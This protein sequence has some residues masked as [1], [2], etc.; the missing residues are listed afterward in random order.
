MYNVWNFPAV[1]QWFY[2]NKKILTGKKSEYWCV[3]KRWQS[4]GY[5]FSNLVPLAK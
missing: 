3:L 1:N 5:Y 4:L 2:Q